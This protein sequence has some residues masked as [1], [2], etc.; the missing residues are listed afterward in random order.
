MWTCW[1]FE[2][3]FLKIVHQ[4]GLF[5]AIKENPNFPHCRRILDSYWQWL[6]KLG[7]MYQTAHQN[8][9]L[10]AAV[11]ATLPVYAMIPNQ[12]N[13]TRPDERF[14]FSTSLLG[15]LN[16]ASSRY[17]QER[18]GTVTFIL[19]FFPYRIVNLLNISSVLPNF[20]HFSQRF[21]TIQSWY[22]FHLH[23]ARL[24]ARIWTLISLL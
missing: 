22:G 13:F 21:I 18:S 19:K 8:D 12:Q 14:N 2:S 9:G 7:K 5:D 24:L 20:R 6:L 11:N 23:G 17:F 10:N 1:N 3:T 16:R 15:L 4:K